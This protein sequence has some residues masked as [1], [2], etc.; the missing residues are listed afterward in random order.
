MDRLSALDADKIH[1]QN[2][3]VHM[4]FVGKGSALLA[5][6]SGNDVTCY[7]E[8]LTFHNTTRYEEYFARIELAWMRLGGKPHW[9]KLVFEPDRVS[10]LY[11]KSNLEDFLEV[12]KRLDPEEVFV[13]PYLRRVLGLW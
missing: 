4:R 7:I 3:V 12:R 11:D 9:G 6:S 8:I 10:E 13:N 5:P 1:P 2:L